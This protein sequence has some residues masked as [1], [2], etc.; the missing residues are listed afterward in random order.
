MKQTKQLFQK[1]CTTRAKKILGLI[2]SDVYG[3]M[4][5]ASIGGTI[6]C[7]TFIDDFSRKTF[8][9]NQNVMFSENVYEFKALAENQ[10]G[11]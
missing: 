9:L 10:T 8:F 11:K 2:D 6:Y 3:L 1:R 7:L 5:V 4:N